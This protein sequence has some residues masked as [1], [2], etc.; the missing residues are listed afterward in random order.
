M[1]NIFHVERAANKI[2]LGIV[3]TTIVVTPL[4]ASKPLALN[5]S[6]EL[7]SITIGTSLD[8]TRPTLNTI[9]DIR[10][11]DSPQF[12]G[13]TIT[14]ASQVEILIADSS[15]SSSSRLITHN[16]TGGLWIETITNHPLYFATNS[17]NARLAISA[18]GNIGVWEALPETLLELTST[19]PYVTLHNSTHEDGDGGR[20]S[21]INFKGE[22]GVDPF[23]ETTLVRIE[24]SHDG[25]G[26]DDKGKFVI[27]INDGDD[28]DTPTQALEIGSDLLATFAGNIT[29]AG[30]TS[31]GDLD[32]G[33]SYKVDSTQVVSNQGA[34]VADATDAA[35]TMARLNELLAR[36]RAHGLITT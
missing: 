31:T 15:I 4:T 26:A 6:K 22:Q 19:V 2:T 11:V 9:Q 30:I 12:A 1:A 27:S 33:G 14:E 21:R 5:A 34:A 8:Y 29:A 28:G 18:A 24:A 13:L 36:C 16:G 32:V 35:T 20:E 7:E 10:I 25:A 3:D 17:S 23:E